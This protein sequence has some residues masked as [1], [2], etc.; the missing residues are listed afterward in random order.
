LIACDCCAAC[1][2]ASSKRLSTLSSC[3]ANT[4]YRHASSLLSYASA[5]SVPL[6]LELCILLQCMLLRDAHRPDGWHGASL[7]YHVH[8]Y[9]LPSLPAS[10]AAAI[11]GPPPASC[12]QQHTKHSVSHSLMC[13]RC[14]RCNNGSA[15]TYSKQ[16]SSKQVRYMQQWAQATSSGGVSTATHLSSDSACAKKHTRRLQPTPSVHI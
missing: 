11:Q 7:P 4:C 8:A 6:L 10:A 9:L 1:C 16:C 2:S 14:H 3:C 13:H 15:Y 5:L 12:K